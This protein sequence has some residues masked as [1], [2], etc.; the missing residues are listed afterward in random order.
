MKLRAGEYEFERGEGTWWHWTDRNGRIV[1]EQNTLVCA[2]LDALARES[3]LCRD[4]REF[5]ERCGS[6]DHPTRLLV[7]DRRQLT[8]TRDE[9]CRCCRAYDVRRDAEKGTA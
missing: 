6:P 7:G 4:Y 5:H 3:E 2:L 9:R 1:S 8:F